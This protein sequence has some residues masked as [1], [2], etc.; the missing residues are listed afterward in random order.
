MRGF[1]FCVIFKKSNGKYN[2]NRA[3]EPACVPTLR[4]YCNP[5][6]EYVAAFFVFKRYSAVTAFVCFAGSAYGLVS[7]DTNDSELAKQSPSSNDEGFFVYTKS[8]DSQYSLF[9]ICRQSLNPEYSNKLEVDYTLCS[10]CV[11]Y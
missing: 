10:Y 6:G 3:V 8:A 2:P 7:F 4:E 5:V 9:K 11:L 1:L